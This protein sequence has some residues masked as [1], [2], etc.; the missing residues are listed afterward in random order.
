MS[1]QKTPQVQLLY[2]A[3]CPNVE[4]ARRNLKAAAVAWT[5]VDIQSQTAPK[6]L[7]GF[8]SPTVLIGGKDVVSGA[9]TAEGDAACRIGGVP[10]VA[11]IRA[12]LDTVG[13]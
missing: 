10:S 12:G 6:H 11:A 3:G 1:A 4:E 2:F 13:Q 5:E 8:P 7:R 9:A